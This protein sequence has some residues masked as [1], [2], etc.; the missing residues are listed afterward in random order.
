MRSGAV[1][2]LK[3]ALPLAALALVVAVFTAPRGD[4]ELDFSDVDFDFRDGLRLVAPRFTGTDSAGRPFRVTAEWALP[5]K[6]DPERVELGPVDGEIVL[7]AG[8]TVSLAAGGGEI[9]PKARRLRLSGGV[10]VET[11]DGWRLSAPTA[12]A[13]LDAETLVAEG[14][15]RGAGPSGEIDA[16]AMRAARRDGEDYIWFERGVRLRIDP[17]AAGPSDAEEAR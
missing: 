13:D 15:V 11:D 6:P 16:G 7:D 17:A 14:P 2:F 9:L 3:I 1:R 5:D 10:T 8:R 12:R 4:F